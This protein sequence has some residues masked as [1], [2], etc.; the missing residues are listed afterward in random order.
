MK[1]NLYLIVG[2]MAAVFVLGWGCGRAPESGSIRIRSSSSRARPALANHDERAGGTLQRRLSAASR[3]DAFR[4][5]ACL[6][7]RP[8]GSGSTF[9]R[10][11]L[12]SG[13]LRNLAR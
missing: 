9:L 6:Q 12:R 3:A 8:A 5:K 11:P 13:G 10:P 1:K 4:T 7:A 2:S